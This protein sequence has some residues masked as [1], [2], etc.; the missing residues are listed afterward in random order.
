MISKRQKTC[1]VC[2]KQLTTTIKFATEARLI[3]AKY[4]QW[5]LSN[6]MSLIVKTDEDILGLQ[7]F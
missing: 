1:E 6:K 2:Q 3:A 4:L 7:E 5:I